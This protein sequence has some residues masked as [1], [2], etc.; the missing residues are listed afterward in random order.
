MFKS[1]DVIARTHEIPSIRTLNQAIK[2][3]QIL[4]EFDKY[5]DKLMRE[6]TNDDLQLSRENMQKYIG[7]PATLRKIFRML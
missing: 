6:A 5:I 2:K 4:L 1:L 7:G 3:N